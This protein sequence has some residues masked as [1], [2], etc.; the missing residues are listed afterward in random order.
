MRILSQK[1]GRPRGEKYACAAKG[2]GGPFFP[3]KKEKYIAL[4]RRKK[5]V[6]THKIRKKKTIRTFPIQKKDWVCDGTEAK[7]SV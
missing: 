6:G 3:K 5:G 2:L 1:R 7:V 4:E